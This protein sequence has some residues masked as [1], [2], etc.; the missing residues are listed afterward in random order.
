MGEGFAKAAKTATALSVAVLAIGTM[1]LKS[2]MKLSEGMG[3]IATLL[4]EPAGRIDV[5][6]SGVQ[7]LA[8]EFGKST[9]DIAEGTYQVISAFQD[10]AETL[11]LVKINA[12][13]AAAGMATTKDAIALTSAVTKGYGDVSADAVKKASGLA[14]Q[15]VKLGQTTF[16]ELAASIGR[17]VPLMSIRREARGIICWICHLDRSYGNRQ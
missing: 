3:N 5:L 11:D 10:S 8:V 1:A 7:G 9:E 14:F 13:A 2:S 6:K 12:M 17:T 4:D 16:P 15:T